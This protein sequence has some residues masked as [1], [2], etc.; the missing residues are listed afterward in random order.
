MSDLTD[1]VVVITGAAGN[2]GETVA[3]AFQAA[4]A[5]LV[6]VDR[7]PDRLPRLFPEL[8]DSEGH[9]LATS[10]DLTDEAAV[11]GMVEEALKRFG[12]IDVLVNTAGGYRGGTPVHETSLDTWDL[13]LNLNARTLLIA[14]SAVIPAMLEQGMGKIVNVGS[15]SALKG[16]GKSAAYSASKCAVMRLTESMSAELKTSG[17]NVNCILP[18]TIDT[19]QNREAMPM[20]DTSRWVPPEALAD[21]IL[22]LAS[23]AARAVHGAAIPVYGT[24]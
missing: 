5:K 12:R 7:K 19:P 6:L 3:R 4:G 14:S 23:D 20:A 11:Q 16:G 13:L 17:I 9:Y 15:R 21:V 1:R 10:V 2:L 22:F 24:G 8:A 18:G